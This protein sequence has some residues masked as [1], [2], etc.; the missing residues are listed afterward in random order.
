MKNEP[1]LSIITPVHNSAT[2]V[3]R[4]MDSILDQ[5]YTSIEMIIVDNASTDDTPNIINS[6]VP[7]FKEKG[8]SLTYTREDDMGPSYGLQT[9]MKMMHGDYVTF[10]DSDDYYLDTHAIEYMVD[11]FES[12]PD[13]YAV[14]RCMVHQIAEVDL[15][16][17]GVWGETANEGVNDSIFEDCLYGSNYYYV[18]IALMIRVSAFKELVGL[19]FFTSYR[20][21]PGRQILMPLYYARKCYTIKKVLCAYL[22]REKS[23]CHGDYAQYDVRK[24][25]YQE[26]PRYYHAIFDSIKS[27]SEKEN[28]FYF[29]D[30]M[31]RETISMIDYILKYHSKWEALKYCPMLYIYTPNHI[32]GIKRTLK[33]MYRIA[34]YSR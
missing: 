18:N 25:L 24:T 9:G 31:Y 11:K 32:K 27:M 28:K 14:V 8:Y 33:N 2:F 30:M 5:T 21:G 10:P 12:L 3:H 1:L 15:R 13:D 34:G 4:L 17:L 7:K 26:Y 29:N 6:Y 19:D 16:L 23:I 20:F 22:V